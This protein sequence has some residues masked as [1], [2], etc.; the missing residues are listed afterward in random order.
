[1]SE[2]LYTEPENTGNQ[3]TIII[4]AVVVVLLLCCCVIALV[5]GWFLGDPIMEMLGM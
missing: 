2:E 3:K 1:M 4:I 5:G